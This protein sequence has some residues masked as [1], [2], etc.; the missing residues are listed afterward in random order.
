MQGILSPLFDCVTL[1]ETF[2]DLP[3]LI[4]TGQVILPIAVLGLFSKFY[5]N[6]E[7]SALPARMVSTV[8]L[9]LANACLVVWQTA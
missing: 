7:V 4:G 2:Q 8:S 9:R 6:A 1:L 3:H 5:F